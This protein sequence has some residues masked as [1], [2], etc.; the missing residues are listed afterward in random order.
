MAGFERA[1]RFAAI[2]VNGSLSIATVPKRSD[3]NRPAVSIPCDHLLISGTPGVP[4]QPPF[5]AQLGN[6]RN[7]PKLAV[8]PSQFCSKAVR[9]LH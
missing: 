1:R 2:L 9:R 4:R 7:V 8:P 6:D 3:G 5:P